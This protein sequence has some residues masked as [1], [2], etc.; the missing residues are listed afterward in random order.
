M[1]SSFRVLGID[2]GSQFTGYGVL[3]TRGT[4]LVLI[5]AGCIAPKS[6]LPIAKRLAAIHAGLVE[7]IARVAPAHAAVEEVFFAKNVKSAIALG[8][9]RGVALAA[10]AA[11]GVEVHEYAATEVKRAVVGT[12]RAEKEQVAHMVRVLLGAQSA[13]LR[14][15]RLDVTDACAIAICHANTWRMQLRVSG[16]R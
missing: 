11:A 13:A 7:L 12:G 3:E 16:A 1:A 9:A 4:Q 10:I 8:Q 15:A 2:P 6:T 14:D 5:E